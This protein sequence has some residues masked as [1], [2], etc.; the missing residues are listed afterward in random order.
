MMLRP[1]P[2][3]RRKV[4]PRDLLA[5][6]HSCVGSPRRCAKSAS[7]S[8]LIAR[9]AASGRA[10]SPL[11]LRK[12]GAP[13]RPYRPDRPTAQDINHI[14]RD[15]RDGNGSTVPPTVPLNTLKNK[16]WDGADGRDANFHTQTSK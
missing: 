7:K 1:K 12:E 2:N 6:D 4:G 15:G 5:S 9:R 8:C 14:D 16:V 13:D 10:Q 3:R 11:L